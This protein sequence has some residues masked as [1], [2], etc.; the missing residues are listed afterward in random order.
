MPRSP[1]ELLVPPGIRPDSAWCAKQVQESAALPTAVPVPAPVS[2]PAPIPAA[3]APMLYLSPRLPWIFTPGPPGVLEE[4]TP[5]PDR[6]VPGRTATPAAYASV[7][8]PQ[9]TA[10]HLH[11]S[12]VPLAAGVSAPPDLLQ[13]AAS[14]SGSNYLSLCLDP[15]GSAAK[16][17][18]PTVSDQESLSSSER[19]RGERV[20]V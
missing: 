12:T 7:P 16:T 3:A 5:S 17:P 10:S 4:G 1:F 20:A 2:V 18:L 13:R 19:R 15:A 11:S 8:Q 9:A 14:A 6:V